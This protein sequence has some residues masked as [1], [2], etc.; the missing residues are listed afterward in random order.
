MTGGLCWD[1]GSGAGTD[2]VSLTMGQE[3][4]GRELKLLLGEDEQVEIRQNLP[5]RLAAPV[6]AGQKVG[7]VEYR[8]NGQTV[9]SF[10]VYTENGVEQITLKRC[11]LRVGALFGG[12]WEGQRSA[13]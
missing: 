11:L 8:L 6:R 4:V 2:Q 12:L 1:D 5:V 3:S 10:P 13:G 9:R 7:T